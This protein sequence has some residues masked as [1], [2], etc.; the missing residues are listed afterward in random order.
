MM[1]QPNN[2]YMMKP[3]KT[4]DM[5]VSEPN[6]ILAIP[7]DGIRGEQV[8]GWISEAMMDLFVAHW[9]LRKEMQGRVQVSR[10]LQTSRD[11]TRKNA[12]MTIS[13]FMGF[14]GSSCFMCPFVSD[15]ARC[16][17]MSRFGIAVHMCKVCNQMKK[18]QIA[19][20][21]CKH[22]KNGGTCK[23]CE[24]ERSTDRDRGREPS[25]CGDLVALRR[26]LP[27]HSTRFPASLPLAF[28]F[29]CVLPDSCPQCKTFRSLQT[30]D[31]NL[32]RPS[33]VPA[34]AFSPHLHI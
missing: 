30:C 23:R 14:W 10:T 1:M 22:F 20:V 16:P 12:F 28:H 11:S 17:R 9:H 25:S 33:A 4:A 34:F 13:D 29:A 3:Q 6:F 24:G 7:K 8:G 32:R 26:P 31:A 15:K 18:P 19:I 2:V 27:S 5:I 21:G